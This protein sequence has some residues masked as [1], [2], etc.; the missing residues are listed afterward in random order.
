MSNNNRTLSILNAETQHQIKGYEDYNL[1]KITVVDG[2][3][4][5]EGHRYILTRE[6]LKDGD[7]VETCK[8]TELLA[9]AGVEDDSYNNLPLRLYRPLSRVASGFTVKKEIL[10]QD[11]P[12][13][14]AHGREGYNLYEAERKA[15]QG[16]KGDLVKIF[17]QTTYNP[18]EVIR[19]DE[20]S[21]L[22]GFIP[23]NIAVTDAQ[24]ELYTHDNEKYQKRVWDTLKRACGVSHAL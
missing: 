12:S 22:T 16:Y 5:G 23:H 9:V 8:G 17:S 18:G 15:T 24:P 20:V 2:Y 19:S 7:T 21:P 6:K 14:T 13:H 11:W 1:Y 10:R 4:F 3:R